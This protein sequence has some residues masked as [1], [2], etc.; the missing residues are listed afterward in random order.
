M[1]RD[2]DFPMTSSSLGRVARIRGWIFPA[3]RMVAAKSFRRVDRERGK[4]ENCHNAAVVMVMLRNIGAHG[5][6]A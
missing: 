1:Y 2:A 5:H 4:I 3:R 6:R